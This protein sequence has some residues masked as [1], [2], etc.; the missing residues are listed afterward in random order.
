[1]VSLIKNELSKV[2]FDHSFVIKSTR[3]TDR[4]DQTLIMLLFGW[5]MIKE[6]ST[7]YIS[8]KTI[9]GKYLAVP[10]GLSRAQHGFTKVILIDTRVC[11]TFIKGPNEQ[12]A[13][14]FFPLNILS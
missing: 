10:S 1:M 6:D 12:K 13:L 4:T 14:I 5:K 2:I 7:D 8:H 9:G 3:Q 11:E